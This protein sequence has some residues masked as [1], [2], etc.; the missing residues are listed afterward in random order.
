MPQ[1]KND[2]WDMVIFADTIVD[3][4]GKILEKPNTE[5]EAY[6][7]ISS[8]AGR[9]HLVHTSVNIVVKRFDA[10]IFQ[11]E[12]FETTEVEIGQLSE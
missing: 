8:L 4:D 5:A 7:M 6:E 3:L 11:K 1:L 2:E 10:E 9:W 12:I